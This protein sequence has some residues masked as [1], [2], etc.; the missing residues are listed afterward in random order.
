MHIKWHGTEGGT[1]SK[2]RAFDPGVVESFRPH[3]VI[4]QLGSNDF[5]HGD[6]LSIASAIVELVPLLHNSFLVK[7]ICV[8]QTLYRVSTPAFNQRVR[9]LVKYLKVLLIHETMLIGLANSHK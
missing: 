9:N 8:C 5:V 7:R 1:V 3:T 2:A 4:L 6:S